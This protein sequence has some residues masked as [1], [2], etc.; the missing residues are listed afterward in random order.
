MTAT[1][2][3]GQSSDTM[4]TIGPVILWATGEM[5][6]GFFV[7]CMPTLPRLLTEAPWVRRLMSLSTRTDDSN[8]RRSGRDHTA[9]S[10]KMSHSTK[11]H[12]AYFQI[13]DDLDDAMPLKTLPSDPSAKDGAHADSTN[14]S[15][16]RTTHIQMSSSRITSNKEPF[17]WQ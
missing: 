2:D 16:T 10:N 8:L 7:A 5:S 15:I 9:A 14:S 11:A 12:E 3:F 6:C 4:Y 1:I 13:D 17:D